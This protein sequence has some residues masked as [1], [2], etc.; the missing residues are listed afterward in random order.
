MIEIMVRIAHITHIFRTKWLLPKKYLLSGRFFSLS[1]LLL[2]CQIS[3]PVDVMPEFVINSLPP[4]TRCPTPFDQDPENSGETAFCSDPISMCVYLQ[5]NHL[6]DVFQRFGFS[7]AMRKSS[8]NSFMGHDTDQILVLLNPENNER[9]EIKM[10]A[11]NQYL[12]RQK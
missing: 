12:Y 8:K 1:F 2:D 5:A 4:V 3:F 10:I 6:R 9:S 7:F 11:P